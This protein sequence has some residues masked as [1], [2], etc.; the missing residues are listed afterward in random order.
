VNRNLRL[1]YSLWR[2]HATFVCPNTS[3][4][5]VLVCIHP[6]FKWVHEPSGKTAHNATG[7]HQAG[8][9]RCSNT[10]WRLAAAAW[11]PPILSDSLDHI[12]TIQLLRRVVGGLLLGL[13]LHILERLGHADRMQATERAQHSRSGHS[14][15]RLM[16]RRWTHG[17]S[18]GVAL[19]RV[20]HTDTGAIGRYTRPVNAAGT[21]CC[22]KEEDIYE[23]A[24]L[25]TTRAA[26]LSSQGW[27]RSTLRRTSTV[28][29][30]VGS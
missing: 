11:G 24:I 8:V 27:S 26:P 13:G 19:L 3:A 15:P 2:I 5:L 16:L 29:L 6:C 10:Q 23:A 21:P 12:S 25:P 7:V 17:R 18:C 4:E 28:D 30:H 22:A 20:F 9:R 14:T 1:C